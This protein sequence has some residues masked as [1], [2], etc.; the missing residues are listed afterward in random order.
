MNEFYKYN[1]EKQETN[2]DFSPEKKPKSKWRRFAFSFWIIFLV[3]ILVGVGGSLVY[4]TGFTFSQ[5]NVKSDSVLPLDE[6]Q[7][8]PS[9]D[10]DRINVLILGLRGEGDPDGGLLTDSIM[11]ASLKK[12]TGQVALISIPRDVY[13]TMPGEKYKEKINF[14]YALGY[15]KQN[16]AGEGLLYSKIAVSR[17]TGLNITYAIS[18]DHAEFKE[19]VDILGGIDIY[20]D[21]H[22]VEDQQWVNGG[23][24]G[25]SSAFFIQTETAT[26]SKGELVT[27]QKWVFKIPVGTSHLDGNTALYFVRARYASS[28]FDRVRRQQLVL[29][30]MK[31]KA[32]NLGI[33]GNPVKFSQLMDSL[34]KNVKMDMG[35]ADIVS[36]LSLY[37]KLDTKNIIHRV[38]DTTPE[39]L[40]YQTKSD[41]GAYILLPQGDNFDK[42]REACQNVFN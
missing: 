12:S 41:S 6:N 27:T 30:A 18:V 23:D 33:L 3:I 42:I 13:L 36:L 35:A 16:G 11:V 17:I 1:Q 5:M 10:P 37:P 21:K 9:S 24:A 14:A 19:I 40:L 38:F 31:N 4:K 26:S 22:F 39:G 28:D 34:G 32:M 25:A 7:P 29:Q 20:L 2:G 15:E 8:T